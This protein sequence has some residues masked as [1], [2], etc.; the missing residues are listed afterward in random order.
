MPLRLQKYLVSPPPPPLSTDKTI[1]LDRIYYINLDRRTD[2]K[3]HFL[4]ECERERIDMRLVHR[5][6]AI[7]G[8]TLKLSEKE[9]I[10]FKDCEYRDEPSCKNIMA[11]QLSHYYILKDMIKHG[12]QRVL[13]LQDDVILKKDFNNYLQWVIGSLPKDA[14]IVNI[15]LHRHAYHSQFIPLDLENKKMNVMPCKR[16]INCIIGEIHDNV[17]PCSLAY[18]ATIRGALNLVR[19]FEENGFIHETDW[20]YNHYLMERNIN[21]ASNIALCTGALM[22]SDVWIEDDQLS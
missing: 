11:N 3:E 17:N 12:H 8:K 15:G 6:K 16:T 4:K 22:G 18:I 21:Y 9:T 13:I 19:Y 20:N 5:F 14:E 7:D 1:R 2:R 10:M